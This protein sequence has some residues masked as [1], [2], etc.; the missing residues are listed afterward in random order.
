[1]RPADKPPVIRAVPSTSRNDLYHTTDGYDWVYEHE[2]YSKIDV[3]KPGFFDA[4]RDELRV[5]M[6]IECRLGPIADGIVQL[7]VQ[8]ISAPKKEGEGPIM[9]AVGS[10]RKFTPARH[11]G[12][13]AETDAEQER[14]VA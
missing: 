14:K 1:M 12:S 6:M 2:D 11:D 9:V 5:G 7:W 8:I 13:I 10:S 4:F 3:A